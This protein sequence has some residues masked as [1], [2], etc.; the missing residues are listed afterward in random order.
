MLNSFFSF[1]K[2]VVMQLIQNFNFL[3][4]NS[5]NHFLQI[6]ARHIRSLNRDKIERKEDTDTGREKWIIGIE[7]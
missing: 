7:V 6:I 4:Y 1:V 3:Y 5:R 2:K